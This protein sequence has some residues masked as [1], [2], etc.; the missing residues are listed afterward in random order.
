MSLVPRSVF[1]ASPRRVVVITLTLVACSHG[2]YNPGV[3]W[4]PPSGEYEGAGTFVMKG[5]ATLRSLERE[6][7]HQLKRPEG[8]E[9][10]MVFKPCPYEPPAPTDP[11][12]LVCTERFLVTTPAPEPQRGF[13]LPY[14][15][16][17]IDDLV[18][19]C[20]GRDPPRI[21]IQEMRVFIEWREGSFEEP[22]VPAAIQK[23]TSANDRPGRVIIQAKCADQV[24][25][26]LRTIALFSEAKMTVVLTTFRHVSD[27][28][29]GDPKEPRLE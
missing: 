3:T 18:R 8:D 19:T 25:P 22:R 1:L 26:M 10:A 12:R 5:P 21:S 2:F 9:C 11:A 16:E 24:A 28:S 13:M 23:L 14:C 15:G 27:D 4:K 20:S 29:C 7:L 6:I 17:R